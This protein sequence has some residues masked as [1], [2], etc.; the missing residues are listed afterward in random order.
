MTIDEPA[1]AGDASSPEQ[2]AERRVITA[3]PPS[4]SAAV[5]SPEPA[6]P[7]A[8]TQELPLGPL[9][10][11][12]MRCPT[13]GRIQS[14]GIVCEEDGALLVQAAAIVLRDRPELGPCP[15]CQADLSKREATGTCRKCGADWTL[16]RR[17]R[18]EIEHGPDLAAVSDR[19]SAATHP[20]N[21]DAVWIWRGEARGRPYVVIG[22][23]DGVSNAQ[24]SQFA[25]ALAVLHTGLGVV[26]ALEAGRTDVSALLRDAILDASLRVRK[27]PYDPDAVGAGGRRMSPPATTLVVAILRGDAL[28]ELT[29]GCIG[30]SR[31]YAGGPEGLT[32]RTSDDSWLRKL[33]DEGKSEGEALADP[34]AH[35]IT[36]WVGSSSDAPEVP[37]F[38]ASVTSF[39]LPAGGSVLLCSD[40]VWGYLPHDEALNE[41][42]LPMLAED[43]SALAICRRLIDHAIEIDGGSDNAS[44]VLFRRRTT[45]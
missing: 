10:P 29:F 3:E 15:D 45:T 8:V 30:D 19:C 25:S 28:D 24:R 5:A 41:V 14:E 12:D 34:R 11:D 27:L 26:R 31:G 22:L 32:Q 33:M 7:S 44:A 4:G 23:G 38:E 9:S 2:S 37:P 20:V 40:G 35:A 18:V 39:I 6:A 13:C 42:V 1:N 43:A 36:R 21:Q 17:D 16:P